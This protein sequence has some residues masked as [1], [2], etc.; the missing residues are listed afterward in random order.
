VRLPIFAGALRG[1]WWLPQSGGKVLRILNGTYEPE[2]TRHFREQLKPGATVLDV[3][4]HVGYYTVLSARL[5]GRQ[6]RVFAFEPNPR[7]CGFLRK[8][9]AAN[10]LA[11]VTV[12]QSAVSDTNGVAGF[13]FGTGTGTGHLANSGTVEVRTLRLDDYCADRG[14]VPDAIKIDV[15]GAELDVLRGAQ[16]MISTHH[17]VIFL[18]THGASIHRACMRW[19]QECEYTIRPITGD[20]VK[21]ATELLCTHA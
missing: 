3:G 11:N 4:A 19:L 14:V 6:G 10:R 16:K 1:T 2:Q 8:H 13:D 9:V 7:N 15:E 20:D 12:E 17:P 21:A 18:S 5:V